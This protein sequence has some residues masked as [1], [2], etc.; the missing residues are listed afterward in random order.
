M[1]YNPDSNQTTPKSAFVPLSSVEPRTV[2]YLVEP[3][4]PMGSITIIG[5][6][7][8]SGKTSLLFNLA[9][10]ISAGRAMP[11]Q[12]KDDDIRGKGVVI[13]VTSEN[14]ADVVVRPRLERMGADIDRVIVLN[15]ESNGTVTMTAETVY[16]A[17]DMYHPV[18]III[19]PI[20][21]FLGAEV[22]MNLVSSVRPVLDELAKM[23]KKNNLALILVSHVSKPVLGRAS[24][25]DGLLGSSDFRNA[26]RSIVIVG[27]SPSDGD[28]RII[29]HGK[30]S[31]GPLGPSIA[32][33]IED[34]G[35]IYDGE[36]SLG[37]EDISRVAKGQKGNA[38]NVNHRAKAAMMLHDELDGKDYIEITESTRSLFKKEGIQKGAMYAARD[39]LGLRSVQVGQ[40]PKRRI[41][42]VRNNVDE[43]AFRAHMREM[44]VK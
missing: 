37:V 17:I 18:A 11:F 31:L 23:A 28:T 30:N 42:W 35:V 43:E 29:A 36:T 6:V 7:S 14:E 21:S 13:Y 8:G 2:E 4:I 27:Y 25:L 16:D 1:Q 22:N 12:D 33:H 24:V 9:S 20:Q 19:D 32:F 39:E 5:G 40:P 3:Y 26:A 38:N 15:P 41:F 10:N 34:S 44:L